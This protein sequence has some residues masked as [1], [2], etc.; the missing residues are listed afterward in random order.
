MSYL[1]GSF[2]LIFF[3]KILKQ[4]AFVRFILCENITFGI[5]DSVTDKP[6]FM[7]PGDLSLPIPDKFLVA[8]YISSSYCKFDCK[9]HKDFKRSFQ[10]KI[11]PLNQ[12][13]QV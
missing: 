7:F 1:G 11:S 8:R 5:S 4:F 13:F 3:F 6:K 12:I 10:V 9:R 2:E